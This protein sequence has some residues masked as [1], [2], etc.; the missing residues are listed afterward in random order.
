MDDPAYRDRLQ[1]LARLRHGIRRHPSGDS[2]QTH[3][4]VVYTRGVYDLRDESGHSL[5]RIL[6]DMA[7]APIV[8]ALCGDAEL[9]APPSVF[10]VLRDLLMSPVWSSN[11]QE[12]AKAYALSLFAQLSYLKRSGFDVEGSD[13]YDFIPSEDLDEII[14]AGGDEG[15]D[16]ESALAEVDLPFLIMERP[17][18]TYIAT[19]R[20][21][22]A[23][24]AVRGTARASEWL[25]NL[26]AQAVDGRP[27]APPE[28]HLGFMREVFEGLAEMRKKLGPALDQRRVYVAGHSLGGA[29]AALLAP[30]LRGGQ[31]AY[32]FGSP[33]FGNAGAVAAAPPYAYVRLDDLVPHL[34][35]TAL[36]YADAAPRLDVLGD[37]P[38]VQAPA[39][40]TLKSWLE[41]GRRFAVQHDIKGYCRHLA[42]DARAVS[43]EL[44]FLELRRAY[45]PPAKGAK[46]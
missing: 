4:S 40:L 26:D 22:F 38:P 11:D 12:P 30:R 16:L 8:C 1:K 44:A 24:I 33:R 32:V 21:D 28:H 17:N 29:I 3:P 15:V 14:Q 27:G 25:I 37:G 19:Y 39:G 23:I 7:R 18:F 2:R 5:E 42:R 10:Q 46:P 41:P 20:S 45:A 9:G 43:P 31:T 13:R 6:D 35:P 34:P 36:G